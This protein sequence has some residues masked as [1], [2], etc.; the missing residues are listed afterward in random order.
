[1]KKTNKHL[2]LLLVIFLVCSSFL[3]ADSFTN[4]FPPG[5][6]DRVE[7]EY[8]QDARQRVEQWRDLVVDYQSDN[9]KEKLKQ[10]NRFFN[11]VRFVDDIRVWEKEDYWATPVEFLGRNA[12]DCED[13]AIAKYFTLRALGMP[14]EKLRL[15]YVRALRLKQ[16]HMVLAYFEQPESMPLIL[17]N[18]NKKILPA[19]Y[20][21]DLQPIYSFNAE[22][23]WA[24][25]AQGRGRKLKNK[26]GHSS[27]EILMNR[28]ER[29]Q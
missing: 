7:R 22:G 12:G 5:L 13:F 8:N 15:M 29:G 27:W 25:K 1:M 20:R 4:I 11:L 3:R 28:I 23:L 9:E 24:A 10:V 19:N 21:R 14:P 18:I 2:Y 6:F 26:G 17:D 16:S